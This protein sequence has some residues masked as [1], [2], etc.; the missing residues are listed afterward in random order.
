MELMVALVLSSML[1]V[2]L[3]GL[4][5]RLTSVNR[6]IKKSYPS[7]SWL[8]PV[9][10][11]LQADYGAARSILVESNRIAIEGYGIPTNLFEYEPVGAVAHLPMHIEYKTLPVGEETWLVRTERRLDVPPPDD[12]I[13]TAVCRGVVGF[14]TLRRLETDVAPP[15]LSL[16]LLI[17]DEATDI[18]QV[19]INL[20][21]HGV[22]V[23]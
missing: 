15:V 6:E 4:T 11:Q 12:Q 23:R 9:Q 7:I 22:P 8:G 21:R 1:L 3:L 16:R 20:V 2:T 14:Q 18:Q 10:S 5:A 13:E 19:A 17:A